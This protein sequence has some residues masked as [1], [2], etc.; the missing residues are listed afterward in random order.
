[1]IKTAILTVS[2][3]CSQGNREDVS[4]Q[5]I[6]EML[7]K[8]KFEICQRKTVPD[9][10]LAIADEIKLETGHIFSDRK[11]VKEVFFTI[12]FTANQFIGQDKAIYKRVF[13][14]RF[15]YV[16]KVFAEIKK[17]D[18]TF[19]AI[20]LQRIEARIILEM[21][22]LR[23]SQERP[24]LPIYT[25]HDSIATIKGNEDYVASVMEETLESMIGIKPALKVEYWTQT[26]L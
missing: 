19:L 7:T 2:D 24:R 14:N 17:N 8:D 9:D 5:T 1:M 23:I 11:S 12:L 18:K 25:V 26:E 6:V 10:L 13:K 20:L 4:G 3:T 21:V 15:P 16:Y 22:C